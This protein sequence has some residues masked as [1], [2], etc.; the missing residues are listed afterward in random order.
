MKSTNR[1]ERESRLA[2]LSLNYHVRFDGRY[3]DQGSKLLLALLEHTTPAGK[4]KIRKR[5]KDQT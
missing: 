3:D 1:D 5:K 4:G 2:V